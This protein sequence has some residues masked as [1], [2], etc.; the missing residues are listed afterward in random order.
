MVARGNNRNNG[1]NLGLGC[2]GAGSAL[3]CS[4]GY[5]WRGRLY[6]QGLMI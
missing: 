2:V 3:S 1:S 4:S 6:L 5:Y